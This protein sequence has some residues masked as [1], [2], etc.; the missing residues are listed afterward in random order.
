M[1]KLGFSSFLG[2]FAIFASA[3]PAQA[4]PIL[5]PEEIDGKMPFTSFNLFDDP[6]YQ[7]GSEWGKKLVTVEALAEKSEQYKRAAYATAKVQLT[8]G[9]ATSFY[10]GE[11][12]GH[13]I[14]ATNH[15]VLEDETACLTGRF[16]FTLLKQKAKCIT[17]L[18]HWPEIDL[19][20]FEV[21]L[22]QEAAIALKPYGRNLKFDAQFKPGQ[23]LVTIGY[24]I[25]DN[26]GRVL[27]GNEDSDCK[28]F[29]SE[30]KLMADPDDINPADYSA[31]SFA[32]GC[33]ISHGD[34]GSAMVDRETGDVLGII[35][36]GRIPKNPK[37]Q[38][39][40]YLDDLLK[41]DS[42]EIWKELSY[43]VPAPKMK[44]HLKGVLERGGLNRAVAGMIKSVI[45]D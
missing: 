9:N 3:G 40:K 38:D 6:R 30:S 5:P 41:T 34:S 17:F 4:L 28:V 14:M 8:Q 22:S 20:L 12:N 31:W 15:H 11:F 13:H 37:V 32:N 24:G 2:L 43:A 26:P 21:E 19:A 29:S 25:A 42:P 44:E 18:G 27:M 16:T 35:W 1:K 33:D 36:T 45:G 7:V 10:L 39:S 23:P